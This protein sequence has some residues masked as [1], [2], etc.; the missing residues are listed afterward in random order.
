MY[1]KA[2][3]SWKKHFDFML[4]D[5]ICL[6]IAFILAYFLRQNKMDIYQSKEYCM[7]TIVIGLFHLCYSNFAESYKNVL[8]R[9]YLKEFFAVVKH[10][11]WTLVCNMSVLFFSKSGEVISR[12]MIMY[13]GVFSVIL[14]YCCHYVWKKILIRKFHIKNE[15]KLLLISEKE[16]A[17]ELLENRNQKLFWDYEII[18]IIL[19]DEEVY[20]KEICGI[21]VV[22]GM[23]EAEN[24]LE[25][26][27]VDE[28]LFA[29]REND[30]LP[31]ELIQRCKIMGLIVHIEIPVSDA[32]L[33][34]A[35][36]EQWSGVF[37]LSNCT[38]MVTENQMLIKRCFDIA[39]SVVGL[40]ITG[41]ISLFVVPAIYIS[42][43]GPVIFS[44]KRVGK[45]GRTFRLYKFRS[46]YQ[47]AEE[48]KKEL[49]N[50]NQISGPMFKL[51]A[52]PR[53]I[54]SGKDGRE[55]GIGWF[56]RTTSIDELPQFWNVLKGDMSLVGTRPP[57]LDEW[58]KYEIQHRA[59]MAIKPGIT[60]MWQ[61]SGRSDIL[62]F[63][64]V[65]R[66]DT[67][68]IRNWSLSLDIKILLK[69]VFVIFSKEGSR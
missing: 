24:Y 31:H 48:R 22:A 69:T 39:G 51:E 56:I 64:E 63:N 5:L 43:P 50:L 27:V 25:N 9:G 1:R 36:V 21:P 11:F 44:Q 54:G 66:L 46:M 65:V 12:L 67:E 37:V 14:L 61:V 16:H 15:R 10:V 29:R 40:L 49:L 4:L 34:T 6:Q 18:G 62:D 52:D 42:D 28:V 60:G 55:K 2:S 26:H 35:V 41:I 57:T 23:G 59:R 45:N 68:Y 17:R 32:I 3:V 33:E 20:E 58:E 19:T 53:I 13:F 30:E 47:D 8:S 38:K 7:L